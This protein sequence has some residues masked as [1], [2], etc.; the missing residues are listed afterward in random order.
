MK[1]LCSLVLACAMLFSLMLPAGMTAFAT[2]LN[3]AATAEVIA[4]GQPASVLFDVGYQ[5]KNYARRNEKYYKFTAPAT[6]YYEITV[7]G[8]ENDVYAT[9][10]SP[11]VSV[12]VKD[13]NGTSVGSVSTNEITGETKKAFQLTKDATYILDVYD[14]GISGIASYADATSSGYASHTLNIV[15]NKHTHTM[16]ESSRYTHRVYYACRYCNYEYGEDVVCQHPHL[17]KTVTK[18]ATYWATGT[19]NAYCPDCYKTVETNKKLAKKAPKLKKA[20]AGEK[21]A[22]VT[23]NKVSGATGYEIQYATKSNFKGAKSVKVKNGKTT[24][25]TI[26]SLK[27]NKKY[28]FRVKAVKG[29]KSSSWSSAKNCKIK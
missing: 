17:Q 6:D 12:N 26:K 24:S 2:A 15:V 20:A 25:K 5:N 29:K 4:L 9:G 28:Y 3:T 27:K 21:Q 14:G 13:S 23:W 18:K 10:K 1:K 19:Y 22:K 8:Y 7:T 11:Y 16:Y